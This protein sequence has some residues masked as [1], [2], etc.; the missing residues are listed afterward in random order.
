MAGSV[1][2]G[3]PRI[4]D[5]DRLLDALRARGHEARLLD[6]DANVSLEVPCGGDAPAACSELVAELEA[7]VGEL[8]VPLVPV[9]G[10]G[11]VFLRPPAS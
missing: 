10:D 8:D 3:T 5:R 4:V 7:L 9:L 11:A 1:E 2:V 6:D